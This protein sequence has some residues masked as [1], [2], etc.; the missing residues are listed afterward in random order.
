MNEPESHYGLIVLQRPAGNWLMHTLVSEY[1]AHHR[2]ERFL[3]AGARPE[4]LTPAGAEGRRCVT[5][6]RRRR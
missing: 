5:A 4:L 6:G 1:L 3:V 2:V